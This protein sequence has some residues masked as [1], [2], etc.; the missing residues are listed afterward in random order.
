MELFKYVVHNG[1][2]VLHR[3]HP[4]AEVLGLVLLPELLAGQSQQAQGDLVAVGFVMLLGQCHGLVVEQAGVGHLDG[5][6]QAVF[7]GTLLL[8][9]ENV[10]ALRQQ[11]LPADVLRLALTG[12]LFRVLGHHL[13][14]VDN[15]DNKLLHRL[16]ILSKRGK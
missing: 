8:K 14:A 3:E 7:V 1:F 6:F 13:R 9:L 4:D 2:L 16:C 5:G 15:I 11:C 12:D 10:Q